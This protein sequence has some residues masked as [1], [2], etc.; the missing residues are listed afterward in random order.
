MVGYKGRVAY[1][2]LE[3]KNLE[4][5]RDFEE[6]RG[7]MEEKMTKKKVSCMGWRLL[8][9]DLEIL[10]SCFESHPFPNSNL[11]C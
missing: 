9:W 3:H 2:G 8:V 1:R 4:E 5:N 7:L 11:W 6:Y 10:A